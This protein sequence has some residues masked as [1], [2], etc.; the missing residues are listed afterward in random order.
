MNLEERGPVVDKDAC[1]PKLYSFLLSNIFIIR[2]NIRISCWY[3]KAFNKIINKNEINQ[4]LYLALL[5]RGV[6]TL[7]SPRPV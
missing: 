4:I 6:K 5:S 3:Y 2:R 1:S 7:R